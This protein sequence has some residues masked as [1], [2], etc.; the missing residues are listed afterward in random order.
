MALKTAFLFLRAMH[1]IFVVVNAIL[2]HTY[3]RIILQFS[4][5]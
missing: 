4:G 3:E 2:V 1:L 5:M